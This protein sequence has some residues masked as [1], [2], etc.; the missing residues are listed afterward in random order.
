M[1]LWWTWGGDVVSTS[2]AEEN[3]P[4]LWSGGIEW[5][6]DAPVKGYWQTSEA[7]TARTGEPKV[8][9]AVGGRWVANVIRSASWRLGRSEWLSVLS[10]STASFSV[11]GA[12]DWEPMAEVVIGVM[13]DVTDQHS[14]A[15]WVGYLDAT[16]ELHE[17][18]AR[19]T[20]SAACVDVVG[21]L[22]QA[23]VPDEFP[24][25]QWPRSGVGPLIEA[26]AALAGTY[27]SV[28]DDSTLA[29]DD[30]VV[31][32]YE[33]GE[34]LLAFVNR[35][36]QGDNLSLFLRG[37]GR[38]VVVRRYYLSAP[39]LDPAP[40]TVTLS[41]A[42]LPATWEVETSP[43]SVYNHWGGQGFALTA[44]MSASREAY[45][46]RTYSGI[47][48]GGGVGYD[49]LAASGVTDQPRPMLASSDIPIT[50]LGHPALFLDPADWLVLDGTTYQA[51]S[52]EHSVEPG[53]RWRAGVTGDPTQP[54]LREASE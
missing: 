3:A 39:D 5:D 23:G 19:V 27:V 34:T 52:V 42:D 43:T 12:V 21:R 28:V 33:D 13:S 44:S 25:L 32:E 29:T 7:A 49:L 2:D 37:S 18:P 51:L 50:D 30:P 35:V 40:A 20:T 22:G 31:L 14:D 48:E 1:S 36:E 17:P 9:I 45:G 16:R 41:G 53:R 38:L 26:V 8:S 15:L 4:S 6:G 54:L 24:T 47:P 10:P 46:Q 11:E